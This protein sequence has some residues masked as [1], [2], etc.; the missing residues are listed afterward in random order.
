MKRGLVTGGS[1]TIGVAICQTL[2]RQGL[3]VIVHA[4]S[5]LERASRVVDQIVAEGN[6]AES[7]GF[8]PDLCYR[9]FKECVISVD[10]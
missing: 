10:C 2:A 1:G 6:S 7:V 5:H 9:L 8:A 3:H 4:H